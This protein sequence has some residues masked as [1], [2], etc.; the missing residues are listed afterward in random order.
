MLRAGLCVCLFSSN[1]HHKN[2]IICI[3]I[4]DFGTICIKIFYT[5]CIKFFYFF[6]SLSQC[7]FLKIR[8]W[9]WKWKWVA[10]SCLT[11]CDAMSYTIHGILQARILEWVAIPISKGSSQPLFNATKGYTKEYSLCSFSNHYIKWCWGF[12]GGANSKKFVC[13]AGDLGLILGSGRSPGEGMATH[14]SILAWRIPMDTGAW[15]AA[16]QGVAKRQTWL[17][18]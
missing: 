10:Q 6:F 1:Q 5:I 13:N 2:D 14:S 18:D 11:L 12:P 8:P 7:Q 9:T 3:K 15:R 17:G 4:G 16:V